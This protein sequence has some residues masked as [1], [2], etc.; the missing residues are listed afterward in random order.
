M[1]SRQPRETTNPYI[2][3]LFDHL[4]R[5]PEL[6]VTPFS[7]RR[8]LLGRYDVFHVQW[9]EVL[10]SGR[11]PLRR[12]VNEL[13]YLALL[14]RL[15]VGGTA[16]VRTAHNVRPHESTGIV[17]RWL[18]SLT[19]RQT[20]VAIRLNEHTDVPA[21]LPVTIRHGHYRDWFAG[22]PVEV[23]HRPR[24]LL[25]F[26]LVRGYKG[27]EELLDVVARAPGEDVELRIVGAPADPAL[28]D[29][30]RRAAASDPRVTCDLRYVDDE[31]LAREV[32]E[33][34]VVVL[35]YRAMHNSGALLLALSLDRPVLAPA[36]GVTDGLARE[37]GE[38]WLRRY[39]R[40]TMAELR[41]ALDEPA[42]PGRPD[43]AARDWPASAEA[44]LRAYR[45]AVGA[46]S[47]RVDQQ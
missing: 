33:A 36:N 20:A 29:R 9:P 22:C 42:P 41:A 7:W 4:A 43:L 16:L 3:Q 23:E 30:V 11:S 15:R 47:G 1:S 37:V 18:W 25:Y 19:V 2:A 32:R 13:R 10:V 46:V 31:T 45:A 27:L 28:A 35:P 26:G 44:H 5:M 6:D 34:A 8:A 17:A 40:L 38:R 14:V 24:R 21:G 39:H 12:R